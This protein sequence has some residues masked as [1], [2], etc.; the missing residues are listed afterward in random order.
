[1]VEA[2]VGVAPLP[3]LA[4]PAVD[5]PVLTFRKLVAPVI[6]RDLYLIKRVGRDLSPAGRALHRGILSAAQ[7]IRDRAA[8]EWLPPS[9]ASKAHR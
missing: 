9:A 4:W 7:A 8:T 3:S 6:E 1:M 5:H 2:G